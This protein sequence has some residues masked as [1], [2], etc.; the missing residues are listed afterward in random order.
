MQPT[1]DW[2]SEGEGSLARVAD[3]ATSPAL[4]GL[5]VQAAPTKEKATPAEEKE[6]K[7]LAAEPPAEIGGILIKRPR[8]PQDGKHSCSHI[9]LL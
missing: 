7:R 5:H 3:P 1:C 8:S 2:F 4:D 6:K 9:F